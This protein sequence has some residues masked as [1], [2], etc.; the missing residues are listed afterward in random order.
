MRKLTRITIRLEEPLYEA[1]AAQARVEQK[2]PAEI[3][4]DRLR[5]AFLGPARK[6]KRSTD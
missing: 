4:R 2:F 3:A 1:I 5:D 6:P